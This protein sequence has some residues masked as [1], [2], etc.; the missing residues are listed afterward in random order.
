LARNDL[1]RAMSTHA[2][3]VR[4]AEGLRQVA[5]LLTAAPVLP[6]RTR[7]ALEDTALT[8]TAAAVVA[9]ALQRTESRGC[10]HRSEYPN[11]DRTMA[12]STV[13][14]QPAVACG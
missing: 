1:Q 9:A 7:T 11:T 13:V 14:A 12:V 2:S 4:D 8:A 10:H 3:V 6:Q 5:D